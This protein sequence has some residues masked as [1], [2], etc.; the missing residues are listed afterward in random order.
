VQNSFAL[1]FILVQAEVD[2]ANFFYFFCKK[3]WVFVVTICTSSESEK[4]EK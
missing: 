4:N 2:G 3:V 1:K